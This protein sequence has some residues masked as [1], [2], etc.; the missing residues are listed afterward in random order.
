MWDLLWTPWASMFDSF[1]RSIVALSASVSLASC[2]DFEQTLRTLPALEPVMF[3]VLDLLWNPLGKSRAEN[4]DLAGPRTWRVLRR[5][6]EIR[7]V[8]RFGLL[9]SGLRDMEAAWFR[10]L[11]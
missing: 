6:V 8:E 5:I 11:E 7:L 10:N 9:T 2:I 3:F 4:C 1:H